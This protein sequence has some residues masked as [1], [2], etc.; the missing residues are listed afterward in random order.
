MFFILFYV[1]LIS[2]NNVKKLVKSVL[3]SLTAFLVY[4]YRR[5]VFLTLPDVD[6]H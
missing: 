6:V 1:M 5:R 3:Y 4:D 2:R